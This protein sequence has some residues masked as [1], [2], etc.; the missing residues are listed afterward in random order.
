[1]QRTG[2]SPDGTP[3]T[4]VTQ[5]TGKVNGDTVEKAGESV[6]SSPAEYADVE[7]KADPAALKTDSWTRRGRWHGM[8][9]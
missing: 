2:S 6:E 1:M 4:T 3:A 8:R 5:Q 9:G 7:L